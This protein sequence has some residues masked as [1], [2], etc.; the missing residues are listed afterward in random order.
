MH[1][2]LKALQLVSEFIFIIEAK[3]HINYDKTSKS[4]TIKDVK[5]IM[6]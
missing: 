2:D 1:K 4:N 3:M 5:R 6:F